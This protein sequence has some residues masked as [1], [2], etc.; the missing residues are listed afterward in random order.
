MTK[1]RVN[2]ISIILVV[3]ILLLILPQSS[4]AEDDFSR[5]LAGLR[6]EALAKGISKKTL[7]A[8]LTG[9]QPIQQVITLDRN[10]PEFKKDYWSYIKLT[11]T[12]TRIK[13]GRELL[14]KH[15]LLLEDIKKKYGV[16]PSF[17]VAIWGLETNFG[18]YIG[19]FSVIGSVATLAHDTRRS[20]FFRAE[21]LNALKILDEGHINVSDMQ[22]SW[23]GAMG[24]LQFMPS[25]FINFA[26]DWDKDGR[27]DIW[28]SLPDVY[29]SA[30]NFLSGNGWDPDV[31]WGKIVRLPQRFDQSLTGLKIE[32]PMAKWQKIGIR[33]IN[34]SSLPDLKINASLIQ[35]SGS[36]GPSFLVYR[37]FR[38]I[39]QWNP[40]FLYALA[41]C[42][43]ADQL[44]Q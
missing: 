41:V 3:L 37:N 44:A 21:L 9:L 35:P 19:N 13:K 18:A 39:M 22:G 1:R 25:T 15:R 8:A 30:A 26:V 23:A 6:A 38:A 11:I 31:T 32:K 24:Q 12:E 2:I 36:N 20:G 34:G 43:L 4:P 16:E 14:I 42:Q 17:L 7:D 10:Q 33:D 40:S 27:K 5:W 29:A 28:H